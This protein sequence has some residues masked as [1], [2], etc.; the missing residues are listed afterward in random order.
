MLPTSHLVPTEKILCTCKKGEKQLLKIPNFE[1][2]K[3]LE[4]Q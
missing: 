2:K 1:K 4:M 3:N